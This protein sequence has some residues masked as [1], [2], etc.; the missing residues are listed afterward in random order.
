[1]PEPRTT[2]ALAALAGCLFIALTVTN[3][4][5]I[6]GG[7]EVAADDPGG[8]ATVIV[9]VGT[10][11]SCSGLVYGDSFILTAAHCLLDKDFKP[12]LTPQ[13]LTITYGRGLKQPGAPVRQVTAFAIHENYLNQIAAMLA[14]DRDM[15][16]DDAPINA[17]DIGLIRIAGTHPPEASSAVLPEINNEYV[18][19]CIPRLRT[20]PLVWMDVYGFGAAPKGEALHKMRVSA[21]APD[22][23]RRGKEPNLGQ[24]YL[25]RQIIVEPDEP[26]DAGEPARQAR[27]ICHGDSGGPAFFVTTTRSHAV[28]GMPLEL[29]G[30]QP[31]AVGLASRTA[32]PHV[33]SGEPAAEFPVCSDSF[34]L[35]RLDY[36][37]DWILSHMKQMP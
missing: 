31:L 17:E 37:R 24:F 26:P 32:S 14:G 4:G 20:W 25:P 8:R 28:P 7:V 9:T 15:P 6:L 34:F 35:V 3:A 10:H 36:Y 29:T 1:M 12:T 11:Q 22:I 30:G 16:F 33:V 13:D 27:G 23:V 5:A 19:C 21:I 2:P 18:I